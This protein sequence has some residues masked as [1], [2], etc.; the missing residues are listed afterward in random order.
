M[1]VQSRNIVRGLYLRWR[2]V[3]AGEEE[4]GGKEDL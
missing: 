1:S 3:D 2:A 4:R